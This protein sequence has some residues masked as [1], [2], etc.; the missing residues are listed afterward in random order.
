MLSGLRKG[1]TVKNQYF[2]DRNDYFKYDLLIFLAEQ[3]SGIKK[4]S[5][6]WMLTQ[7]DDSRDG[8]KIEYSKGAG[9]RELFRFLRKSMDEGARNVA[10]ISDYFSNAG[11]GFD[12]CPY[13]AETPLLHRNRSAY[14][15][16]IPPES[17]RDAVVFLDP[18]NGLE[19]KSAT[20]K[21]FCK[22]VKFEEV[23]SIFDKMTPDSCLVIYQHLPRIDRNY[24]LYGLY[25]DLKDC[26]KCPL[27]I[28][29]TDNQ[30]AFLM[31]TKEKERR[32]EVNR[33][34]HE[35][36]RSNLQILD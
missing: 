1:G 13:G 33:L 30:V 2:G 19:V 35:Y 15:K 14:F 8:E 3:L 21:T 16:Q 25:R 34:L 22:Y 26:L 28:S 24:F 11:Y 4:L 20:E 29:I 36:V 5:V 6:V 23:K 27:P 10:R 9:D 32:E 7:N 17:L 18:D 31:L 12:Y